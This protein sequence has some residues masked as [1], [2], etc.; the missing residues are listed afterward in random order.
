MRVSVQWGQRNFTNHFQSLGMTL[1]AMVERVTQMP[2]FAYK[3]VRQNVTVNGL[4]YE[5]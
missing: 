4:L 2:G 5:F 1:V 3:C